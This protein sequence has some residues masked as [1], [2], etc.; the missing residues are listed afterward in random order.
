[1]LFVRLARIWICLAI[2][3]YSSRCLHRRSRYTQ[4]AG[5]SRPCGCLDEEK[6]RRKDRK[7]KKKTKTMMMMKEK[8]KKKG[9]KKRKEVIMYTDACLSVCS[10]AATGWMQSPTPDPPTLMHSI[11]EPRSLVLL[12]LVNRVLIRCR[13][14]CP[15]EQGLMLAIYRCVGHVVSSPRCKNGWSIRGGGGVDTNWVSG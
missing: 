3:V 15:V 14:H 1:M 7:R 9:R 5:W 2:M 13:P 4:P 11:H 6:P 12:A 8:K 10:G